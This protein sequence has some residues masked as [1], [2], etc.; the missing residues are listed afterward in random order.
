MGD[1]AVVTLLLT[2]RVVRGVG[3]VV[4]S[5]SASPPGSLDDE[6]EEVE[7]EVEEDNDEL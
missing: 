2:P 4:S 1:D 6:D 5:R 3:S 7:E